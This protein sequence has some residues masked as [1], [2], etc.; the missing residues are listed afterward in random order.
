[1]RNNGYAVGFGWFGRKITSTRF[2]VLGIILLFPCTLH[3]HTT[4]PHWSM[5]AQLVA[6]L[7]HSVLILSLCGPIF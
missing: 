7:V 6:V 5:W 2:R 3:Q 4:G 1:M